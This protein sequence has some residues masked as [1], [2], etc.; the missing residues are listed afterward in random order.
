MFWFVFFSEAESEIKDSCVSTLFGRRRKHY[1]EWGG[2]VMVASTVLW[3]QLPPGSLE[4]DLT[5]DTVFNK[6]RDIAP[7]E[8][9][10]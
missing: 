7:L 9:R 3:N 8:G 1:R 10:S 2:G 5:L 6:L 4:L